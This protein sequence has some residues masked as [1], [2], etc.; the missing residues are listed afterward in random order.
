MVPLALA[1]L[2][3]RWLHV[4]GVAVAVGGAALTWA[5]GRRSAPGEASLAVATVYEFAFWAALGTLVMTGVGNLGAFT[6]S[7]PR[8]RWG[9][10][11]T[12][13]LLLVA[14]ILLLSAVRTAVV[15]AWRQR[16]APDKTALE[17]GYAATTL[18]LVAVVALGEVLAHG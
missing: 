16:S 10:T 4:L 11:L 1:H 5:V 9:A 17:R 7:L 18:S 8:G 6:P 14:A 2:F 12:L 15:V 3:V 13:K